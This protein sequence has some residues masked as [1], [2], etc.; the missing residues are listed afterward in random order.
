VARYEDLPRTIEGLHAHCNDANAID[1]SG[2]FGRDED[3]VIVFIRGKYKGRSLCDI[4]ASKLD[5]LEWMQREDFYNDTKA[6]AT[7]AL[8][9]SVARAS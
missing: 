3:G 5:Y 7:E 4:A 6:I 1:M 2:M 9:R 8:G